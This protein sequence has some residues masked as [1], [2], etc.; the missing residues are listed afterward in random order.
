MGM[1]YLPRASA[2]PS[3]SVDPV[4]VAAERLG[5]VPILGAI[6][7]QELGVTCGEIVEGARLL[8]CAI[9]E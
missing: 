6:S 7:F 5:R 9:A 3:R 8:E 4:A 1:G 2:V